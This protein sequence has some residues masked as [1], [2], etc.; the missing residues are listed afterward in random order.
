MSDSQKTINGIHP[1]G[2]GVIFV[3]GHRNPDTDSIVSAI[4]YAHLKQKL[5][6][7]AVACRCG[8]V[9]PETKM[10][11]ERFNQPEPLL[12]QDA[13]AQMD[14][15][16]VDEPNAI[17][18]TAIL[19]DVIEQFDQDKKVFTVLDEKRKLL[20]MVTN[21]SI[22]DLLW[23][24][25]AKSIDLI[26]E[27]AI[28]DIAKSI[29][30]KILYAPAQT[31][32][33]GKISIAALSANRLKYYDLEDRIV[34]MGN[35]TNAQIEAIHKGAAILILVWTQQVAPMVMEAAKQKKCA[36]ILSGNGT[37]NT[38][39]YLY[40]SIPVT[41]VMS[42]D[43]IV[44]NEAEFVDD[45]K[46]K[47][48]RTRFRAYPV[49]DSENRVMGLTSRYRVLN[50]M[51]RRFILVDH[52][53]RKQAVPNIDKADVLEIIDHH[54][55]GDLTSDLPIAF[56]NEPVGAT[57]TIVS[58]IFLERGVEPDPD[59]QGLLLSAIITDTLNFRSP[60]TSPS[61][62]EMAKYWA[63]KTGL[64]TEEL[65]RD[66][67]MESS[68]QTIEDL[69]KLLHGDMKE[70][71][72]VGNRVVISQ[73]TMYRLNTV[74]AIEDELEKQLEEEV[75]NRGV[76]LWIMIFTSA[77]DNGS[78]FYAAGKGAH[79]IPQ[80][81]PDNEGEKHSFQKGIVSRKNQ[82]VPKLSLYIRENGAL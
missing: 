32:H 42:T 18:P 15:T 30:G 46:E 47:M 26:R 45:V 9:N 79:V 40:Y 63:E 20:G 54:R 80:I 39:R 82:V 35:D 11:L 24:D 8:E 43:L 81:F 31:R 6:I 16:E 44:I 65:A 64:D 73:H 41:K 2:G 3:C 76:D 7:N 52:N 68:R 4:G 70:F 13:R 34:I 60:T 69:H 72:I 12:I 37:M 77:R 78:I 74:E 49:V 75:A 59:I 66:I 38:S 28:E 58:K 51:R 50:A 61:D 14:E 19:R 62:H 36:V 1:Q 57:A 48:I 56:R 22:G 5:G 10:L 27:T 17:P 33:N 55:L 23:G 67:F 53:E 71:D 25:T 21:S 29:D